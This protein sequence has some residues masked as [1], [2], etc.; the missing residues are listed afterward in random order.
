MPSI[1][2]AWQ[3]AVN[4]CNAPNVGYS[5]TYRNQQMVNGITYYDCS[6]FINYAL[7]AGGFSTP[8]YAPSNNAFTTWS[9]PT[10]L[11]NLGFNRVTDGTLK[12]GDIGVSNNSSMQHTE[13]VYAVDSS[14]TKGQWMGA[15]TNAYALANQVSITTYW[16]ANWFDQLWRYQDGAE[17][18]DDPYPDDNPNSGFK[19]SP[20]V[21]AAICGNFWTESGIDPGIWES[22]DAQTDITVQ[23]HGYGLGQ[24]TNVGTPNGRLY[25]LM[26]FLHNNGY[27]MDSGNGEM[28][29]LIAENYWTPHRDYT[30]QNLNEFLSSTST[31][32]TMLTHAWNQCWEGI[33]NN[34]W[35]ARVT[36][37]ENC[38]NYILAHKDDAS[39]TGWITGNRFLSY[40]ERMNN[41]VMLYRWISDNIGSDT[42]P[43]R[44]R[45]R[46]IVLMLRS[47]LLYD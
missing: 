1:T 7:L 24:W 9:E 29:F 25:N 19:V 37:A 3:W 47:P 4:T 21:V 8:S 26:T 46:R 39:I 23:Y 45:K 6:S 17:P 35:D 34:T 5:Q 12:V 33:H 16:S 40:N 11:S 22:L 42:I 31:D 36:Q 32:L 18:K 20:Y 38:Y 2:E 10:V 14:G 30:F 27:P 43:V 41:A 28:E 44:K 15:H 13:M